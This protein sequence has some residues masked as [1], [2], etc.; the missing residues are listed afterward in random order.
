MNVNSQ[1][2]VKTIDENMNSEIYY[3]K[4][5]DIYSLCT[6]STCYQIIVF[7]LSESARESAAVSFVF[8]LLA[9]LVS[10]LVHC[11]FIYLFIM[12]FFVCLFGSVWFLYKLSSWIP[13]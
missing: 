9:C 10:S 8:C 4:K 5:V 1:N 6:K 7:L 12:I 11:L 2:S 3:K 13:V